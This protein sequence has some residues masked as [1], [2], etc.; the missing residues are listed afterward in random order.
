MAGKSAYRLGELQLR[1]M[2]VLW[3][4]GP[5]TVA[6]VQLQLG[7]DLAYTTVATM[8]RKMEARGLVAHHEDNRR[9]LYEA[10]ATSAQAS[11]SVADDLVQRMFEGN[12]AAAVNHLLET[13]DV[14]PDEL[15]ELE[16]LIR[17]H[18]RKK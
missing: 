14:D 1:I 10:V 2:Q 4:A 17:R 12:L 9:F 5:V 15:A 8:L 16:R 13:R 6:D 7:D 3:D 11:Q 18:K